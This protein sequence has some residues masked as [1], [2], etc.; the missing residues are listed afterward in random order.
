MEIPY[1]VHGGFLKCWKTV[2]K[3]II[4]KILEEDPMEV[5][6]Y[7]W[8]HI[9]IV[10]YSHGGAL[11]ALCHECVWF[12]RGD[13]RQGDH[14]LGYGFEAPRVYA[15]WRI[16]KQLRERWC[17]FT[18]YRNKNDLVTH[19]PPLCF[20]FRH[21]GAVKKIGKTSKCGLI[22]AHYRTWVRVGLGEEIPDIK[23]ELKREK[24]W[25]RQKKLTR[26]A[27]KAKQ[28]RMRKNLK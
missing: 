11:A 28:R 8:R 15:G 10:G 9:V 21:V 6:S 2:E 24:A 13:L 12:H 23:A 17:T 20:F 4:H 5:G 19:M 3:I 25:S 7:R 27:E 18:V 22:G 14:I 1:R 16:P 26:A